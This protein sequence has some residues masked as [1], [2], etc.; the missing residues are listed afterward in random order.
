MTSISS[1]VVHIT[2]ISSVSLTS[3]SLVS[4]LETSLEPQ[5]NPTEIPT[6]TIFITV[7]PLVFSVVI[8]IIIVITLIAIVILGKVALWKRKVFIKSDGTNQANVYGKNHTAELVDVLRPITPDI[9]NGNINEIV[10]SSVS[11][12]KGNVYN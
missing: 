5:S 9:S 11:I 10:T 1:A 6:L 12:N 8:V 4:E 7:V 3:F 2:S